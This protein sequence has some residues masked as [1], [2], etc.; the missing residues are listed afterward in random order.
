MKSDP[1]QVI[2]RPV[3]T[4]KTTMNQEFNNV[5]TFAVDRRANKIEIKKAIEEL[6]EVKVDSVRTQIRKGKPR[7]LRGRVFAQPSRKIAM[8][9]LKPGETIAALSH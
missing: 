9:R 8:I 7:R 5:Y 2:K 6:F 1:Y 4:E 3:V